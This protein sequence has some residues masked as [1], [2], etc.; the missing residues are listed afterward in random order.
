MSANAGSAGPRAKDPDGV[1]E[2]EVR[3]F[4]AV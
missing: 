3:G 4:P 1:A 2:T